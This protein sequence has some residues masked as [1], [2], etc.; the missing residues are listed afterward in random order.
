MT[1]SAL[2]LTGEMTTKLLVLVVSRI[3]R[4]PDNYAGLP[5]LVNHELRTSIHCAAPVRST[6]PVKSGADVRQLAASHLFGD[7]LVV[8]PEYTEIKED[9]SS[10]SPCAASLPIRGG[11]TSLAIIESSPNNEETFAIGDSIFNNSTL[12]HVADDH[13]I[14]KPEPSARPTATARSECR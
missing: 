5:A 10:T 4:W 13:V 2:F 11:T 6:L 9:K 1:R 14:L 7:T 3:S 8:A 12:N